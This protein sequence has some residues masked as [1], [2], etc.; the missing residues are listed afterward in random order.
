MTQPTL[1]VIDETAIDVTATTVV[2]LTV[3]D[4][5]NSL[6][7]STAYPTSSEVTHIVP[8]DV[9]VTFANST[10]TEIEII[11][12]IWYDGQERGVDSYANYRNRPGDEQIRRIVSPV[13]LHL[14]AQAKKAAG[15]A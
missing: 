9:T 6:V 13:I 7:A 4:A 11:G 12:R 3:T 5:G 15:L 2:R 1:P 14:I 8:R 10:A